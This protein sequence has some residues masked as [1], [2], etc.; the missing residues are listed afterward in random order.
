MKR[1]ALPQICDCGA[2]GLIVFEPPAPPPPGLPD[3]DP[4]LVAA[5]GG[6]ALHDEGGVVC[7]TCGKRLG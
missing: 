1:F 2:R 6:F 7:R 3:P 5:E 4:I